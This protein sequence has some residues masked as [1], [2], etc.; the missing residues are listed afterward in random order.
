M[1]LRTVA[2]L[3][4]NV[5]GLLSGVDLNN[6]DDVYGCF[7]RAVA[8]M[9]Q[10]AD[11]PEC[12]GIQNIT[13]YD[14][15][16]DY[17]CDDEIFSTAINDIR[18]QGI[19]RSLSNFVFKKSQLDFDR[20]KETYN[21]FGTYSTFKYYNGV[22]IISILAPFPKQKII[23][24]TMSDTTGWVASG[25]AGTIYQDTSTFYH[26]PASLR[27][28]LTNASTGILT[29]T[30]DST[31]IAS[32]TGVGVGFLA[33]EIP[34]GTNATNLTNIEVRIGSDS[35]NYYTATA[36]TGFLGAWTS[37]N[38]TLVSFD[39]ATATGTPNMAKTTYVQ[40]RLTTGA[41]ITNFRVGR[42]WISMPSQAQIFYQTAAVFLT[43]GQTQAN[44]EIVSD[45]DEII[46][47]DP[48]YNIFQYECANA[49]LENVGGGASDATKASINQALHG[50]RARN[51]V[52]IQA[53]L[54]E[55]FSGDN[56]SQELR[57][58]GSWYSQEE[59]YGYNN[60]NY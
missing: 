58:S 22:P 45:T 6:V 46:L 17:L 10:K 13:L 12:M 9:V 28:N 47:Q 2:N 60:R 29:K 50:M 38:W 54:Y 42:L 33:I 36:S 31:D 27:F 16:I 18:P 14:G 37:G 34:Q 44:S 51:G 25:S 53:G 49:V 24:D 57:F 48:A 30:I 3:K 8:T 19:S 56:P 43:P 23:L 5:A 41:T 1:A 15:V 40:V 35:S 20:M 4:T 52:M 11:V 55:M 26:Q 21:N 59:G 32:Y 39:G 7:Q